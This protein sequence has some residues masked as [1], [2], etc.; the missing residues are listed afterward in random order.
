[1][2]R[3]PQK[4]A[5]RARPR[6]W[7]SRYVLPI[8]TLLGFAALLF[9]SA[10]QQLL[11]R[12]AV[13]VV[14]VLVKRSTVQ[15][16][17]TP[18]FQAAGW[19]EPRPTSVSVAALTTGVIEEL[20]V[21]EG[22]TVAKGQTIAR[23]IAIDAELA[24]QQ[25]AAALS[26]REGELQGAQAEHQAAA[27]RL[28]QPV[29]LQAQLADA[30]SLLAQL[31]TQMKKLPFQMTAARATAAYTRRSLEGKREAQSAIAALTVEQ[32]VRDHSTAQAELEEL[33]QRGANL[34]QEMSA[35]REKVNA[36]QTQLELL[37]EERRQLEEAKAKVASASALRDAARLNLQQAQLSLD[38]TQIRAPMSGRILRLIAMPGNRVPAMQENGSQHTGTVVEMYDPKRLQVR[39][40][41]RLEDV[42]RVTP[43]APVRV[44]TASFEAA[45]S[46]RVLQS[47]SSANVQK[48]TLEVK[49]ELIDPPAAVSPEMLV[50]A[51]FLAPD[52]QTDLPSAE[53]DHLY[54]PGQLVQ[55]QDGAAFVWVVDAQDRAIRKSVTTGNEGANG[56]VQIERGLSVTDKLIASGAQTLRSGDRVIVSG[57]DLSLGIGD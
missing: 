41:V 39:A 54:V 53:V 23:L 43:G 28:E 14:P 19:I 17:G 26:L 44:Q 37:I 27:A 30:K 10:G 52:I 56:L 18:L 25:A 36:L 12:T 11:P 22:Q 7:I 21:V 46:G 9:V 47:T 45:I 33:Q 32:A 3:Q 40:D 51:T 31:H 35:L 55:M 15:T 2:H 24:V 49:V 57:E 16:A 38:R 4:P 6:R 42:S 8:G 34:E 5:G 20:Y 29:H 1:M 13:T 48:N 50:T